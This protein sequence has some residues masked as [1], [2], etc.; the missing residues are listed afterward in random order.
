M[1]EILYPYDDFR[2]LLPKL[3]KTPDRVRL[4]DPRRPH[5]KKEMAAV[6]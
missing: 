4:C 5:L 3:A 2:P 1:I 6:R